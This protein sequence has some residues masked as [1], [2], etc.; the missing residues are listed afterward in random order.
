MWNLLQVSSVTDADMNLLKESLI[1]C[2]QIKCTKATL[3]SMV[4]LYTLNHFAESTLV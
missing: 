3:V 2:N 4:A 1:L